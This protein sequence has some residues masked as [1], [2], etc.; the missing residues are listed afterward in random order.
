MHECICRPTKDQH[1]A[2]NATIIFFG[3][4]T[5]I[6]LLLIV[7]ISWNGSWQKCPCDKVVVV[8]AAVVAVT[9]RARFVLP[10]TP[11]VPVIFEG[12]IKYQSL[13]NVLS[14]GGDV[15]FADAGQG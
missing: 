13:S 15:E 6:M 12:I 8:P 4:N 3:H 9:S 7:T 10:S 5:I 2:H 11:C 14:A 1:A